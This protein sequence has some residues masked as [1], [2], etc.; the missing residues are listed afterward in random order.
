[1][2]LG[3]AGTTWYRD[4]SEAGHV[5]A[6]LLLGT[7][8]P[9]VVVGIPRGGVVVAGPVAD[10]LDCPLAL[11]FTRKLTLP[12]WPEVALGAVDEEGHV[13][14]D[15]VRLHELGGRL[16][17]VADARM[18]AAREVRRQRHAFAAPGLA[19]IPREATVVLIDDGLATGYTMRAAIAMARRHGAHRIVVAVPCAW[20]GA[21][22]AIRDEADA[23]VCPRVDDRFPAA[24]HYYGT[25][26]QVTDQEVLAVLD[27]ARGRSAA[28]R[29]SAA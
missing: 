22:G 10:A 26:A 2:T 3:T 17:D 8:A 6:G 16:A 11:A 13:V 23:F 5:L 9:R 1:M 29:R 19:D 27:R 21:A 24:A 28:L 4:R 14:L 20:S 12:D 25:F 18:K 7:P 15:R